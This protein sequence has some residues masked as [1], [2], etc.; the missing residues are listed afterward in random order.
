MDAGALW[1]SM[2]GV[3][4]DRTQGM[5]PQNPQVSPHVSTM[6]DDAL[7]GFID[8]A[9]GTC[10]SSGITN[11]VVNNGVVNNGV[12]NNGGPNNTG[13]NN[14][15]HAQSPTMDFDMSSLLGASPSSHV[16]LDL[17]SILNGMVNGNNHGVSNHSV[18][19]NNQGNITGNITPSPSAVNG[20]VTPM[21]G[22]GM[23]SGGGAGGG[24]NTPGFCNNNPNH[25]TS[26]S[27]HARGGWGSRGVCGM[28]TSSN[29]IE[30]DISQ[31]LGQQMVL[32]LL[33]TR[34]CSSF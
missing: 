30:V 34:L 31:L 28:Q 13:G 20:M 22:G 17:N 14:T 25:S 9:M 27:N 18:I 12:V 23:M 3:G 5:I 7:W 21:T 4:L 6:D 26:W 32:T 11:G 15:G 19:N 33:S 2:V 10:S 1:S 16:S 8:A 24:Q 29:S